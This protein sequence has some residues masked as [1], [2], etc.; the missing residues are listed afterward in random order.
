M[1]R[2]APRDTVARR[3]SHIIALL[4]LKLLLLAFF[5][6]LNAISNYETQKTDAV[7]DSVRKAFNTDPLQQSLIRTGI[8]NLDGTEPVADEISRLFKSFLPAVAVE[9][10]TLSKVLRIKLPAERFFAS[11]GHQLRPGGQVILQRIMGALVD[12]QAELEYFELAF[13]QSESDRNNLRRIETMAQYARDQGLKPRNF[14]VGLSASPED[15]VVFELRL[16]D[17]EPARL[18]FADFA[19]QRP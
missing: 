17:E 5:I 15:E 19:E 2:A 7:V 1:S 10:E 8:D 6:L 4:S 12:R 13:L 16:F 9:E 3:D 11:G 14:S 18:N